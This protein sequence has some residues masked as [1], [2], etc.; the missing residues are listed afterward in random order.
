MTMSQAV[1]AGASL[2]PQKLVGAMA[3]TAA[4]AEIAVRGAVGT[5]SV[6]AII[7]AVRDHPMLSLLLASGIGYLIGSGRRPRVE[8]AP[9]KNGR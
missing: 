2:P 9:I 1:H 5:V 3:N 7:G 8:P 6:Q 4:A